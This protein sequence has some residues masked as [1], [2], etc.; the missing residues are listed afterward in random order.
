MAHSRTRL[1]ECL[2]DWIDAKMPDLD[3]ARRVAIYCCDRLPFEWFV[4]SMSSFR[5]ITLWSS[6]YLRRRSCPI[7]PSDHASVELILHEFVHVRQ[8]RARPLRFPVT[9][10]F[11][12][13]RHGY[14]NNPA[15]VEARELAHALARE[16]VF[17]GPCDGF[18]A[19]GATHASPVPVSEAPSVVRRLQRPDCGFDR[20]DRAILDQM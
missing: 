11:D 13:V 14:R 12:V 4:G 6:V 1:P 3:G 20:S 19:G 16:Y 9:Y 2:A 5:G 17:E 8:F 7:S 10:L 15:E 18:E